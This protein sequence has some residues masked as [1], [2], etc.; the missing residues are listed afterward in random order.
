MNA[1]LHLLT[2]NVLRDSRLSLLHFLWQGA[3]IALVA[4]GPSALTKRASGSLLIGRPRAG[5]DGRRTGVT[6]LIGT[7]AR[8]LQRLS[9]HLAAAAKAA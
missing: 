3:A 1:A 6:F 8:P 7:K 2:P 5:I 4:A 9:V